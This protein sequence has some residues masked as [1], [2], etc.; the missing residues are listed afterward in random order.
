MQ[1]EKKVNFNNMSNEEKKFYIQCAISAMQG[2]QEGGSNISLISDLFPKE[3]AKMA[4]KM[5]DAMLDEYYNHIST[6]PTTTKDWL[7]KKQLK[8]EL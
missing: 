2:M 1:K 8:L 3:T 5:A 6:K 4:F 7:E